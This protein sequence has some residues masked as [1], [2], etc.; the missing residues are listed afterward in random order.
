[1]REVE[2]LAKVRKVTV[3]KGSSQKRRDR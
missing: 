2:S 3:P 1:V